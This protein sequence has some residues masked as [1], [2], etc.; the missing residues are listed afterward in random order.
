MIISHSFITYAALGA[1]RTEFSYDMTRPTIRVSCRRFMWEISCDIF[2]TVPPHSGTNRPQRGTSRV[3]LF[4]A[5]FWNNCLILEKILK[6]Y[7]A[8]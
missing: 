2:L 1:L 6:L 8:F 5:S 4:G 3:S 7:E